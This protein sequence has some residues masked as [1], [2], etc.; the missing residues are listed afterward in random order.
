MS[1]RPQQANDRFKDYIPVAER[2]ELFYADYPEGRINTAIMEH[3]AERGF[4]L[5][6]AEVY[7]QKDD[8]LPSSTGHAYEVRGE[9]HVN[10]TSYIE[11]CETGA[12]GRA[13]ALL[14]YEV[15]RGIASRE[16]MQKADRMPENVKQMP[17]TNQTQKQPPPAQAA[18]DDWKCSAQVRSEILD[19]EAALDAAGIK[20]AQL[21][22]ALEKNKGTRNPATLN[23]DDALSYRDYLKQR[24]DK[25]QQKQSA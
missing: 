21:R 5:M 12:V 25:A 24:N 7:R 23:Q 20:S 11:N 15:K 3:D 9:G 19:L 16:E 14:G 4:I 22:D 1:A 18:S 2:V 8:A 17:Y 13:I 6:R 10:K